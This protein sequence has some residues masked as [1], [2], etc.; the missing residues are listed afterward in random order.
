[1]PTI[2][3]E[4]NENVAAVESKRQLALAYHASLAGDF[5]IFRNFVDTNGSALVSLDEVL[6]KSP[7]DALLLQEC[8]ARAGRFA[9]SSEEASSGL[10]SLARAL[11]KR[12]RVVLKD[13]PFLQ[14]RAQELMAP[15][16]CE[17][18]VHGGDEYSFAIIDEMYEADAR[19]AYA[20]LQPRRGTTG[21]M[22]TLAVA[23]GKPEL[24]SH[25]LSK[26][27]KLCINAAGR[28][29]P[30]AEPTAVM[31]NLLARSVRSRAANA[32]FDGLC[33]FIESDSARALGIAPLDMSECRN[34]LVLKRCLSGCSTSTCLLL[35]ATSHAGRSPKH[36]I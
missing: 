24:V 26:W 34:L 28:A 30:S 20:D 27:P 2:S 22:L 10:R 17:I 11:A 8:V 12:Y 5:R 25:L 13:A 15:A 32:S 6:N 14:S 7:L 23:E 19:H 4:L 9:R 35:G 36:H 1:M 18:L 31:S 3:E 33:G 29:M 21:V 16:L